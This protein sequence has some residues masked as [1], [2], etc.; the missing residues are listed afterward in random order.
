[1]ARLVSPTGT[2]RLAEMFVPTA[3]DLNGGTTLSHREGDTPVGG[4]IAP[5]STVASRLSGVFHSGGDAVDGEPE[6]SLLLVGAVRAAEQ[7]RL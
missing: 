5:R 2:E 6:S 7:V 1:M 4:W 3:E